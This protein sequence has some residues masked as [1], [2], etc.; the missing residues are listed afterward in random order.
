MLVNTIHSYYHYLWL[1]TAMLVGLKILLSFLF[2][3]QLEGFQGLI[4]AVFK[5]YGEDDQELAETT[6]KRTIMRIS[7]VLTAA[8]YFILVL[9]I[10]SSLLPMF[11]SGS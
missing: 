5:W 7:N 6:G 2:N 11:L 10:L 1:L 4:Y 8:M 3:N 9:I